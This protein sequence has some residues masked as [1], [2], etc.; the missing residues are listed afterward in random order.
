MKILITCFFIL[1]FIIVYGQEPNPEFKINVKNLIKENHILFD[2]YTFENSYYDENKL[3]LSKS[4]ARKEL[5]EE[6]KIDSCVF[7]TIYGDNIQCIKITEKHSGKTMQLYFRFC[8]DLIYG[9]LIEIES[10]T[11]KNGIFLYDMCK[12]EAR[13]KSDCLETDG[14]FESQYYF[15]NRPPL[16]FIKPSNKIYLNNLSKHKISNSDLKKIFKLYKCY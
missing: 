8:Q 3:G 15:T 14:H 7:M 10:L 6:E 12:S 1:T 2:H 13:F 9:K 4:Y 16:D 11:F 5:R